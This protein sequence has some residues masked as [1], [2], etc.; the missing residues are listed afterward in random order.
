MFLLDTELYV[1]DHVPRLPEKLARHE[2]KSHHSRADTKGAAKQTLIAG[3]D[4]YDDDYAVGNSI[5]INVHW[6]GKDLATHQQDHDQRPCQTRSFDDVV[7]GNVLIMPRRRRMLVGLEQEDFFAKT[8]GFLGWAFFLLMRVLSISVFAN[9]HW[10][11]AVYLCLG[12]YLVVLACLLYEVKLQAKM[13]RLLF[14]FF[15]GYVYVF[16][17]MEF[18]IKFIH[19]RMWYGLY[20]GLVLTQNFLLSVWWYV[21]VMDLELWW[22]DYLFR[23][24]LGSGVLSLCC[25][26]V[27][28]LRLKPKD[29]VLFE[30]MEE[31]DQD[32]G[33]E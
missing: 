3:L 13:Q 33:N 25:L 7:D 29:K 23:T 30:L 20:V 6:T 9:L 32:Q 27:Y 28:Y 10:R 16:V 11:V 31:T 1:K 8:V 19:L 15:L 24:I 2:F 12:H 4:D 17:I 21:A 14:Y 18:K 26:V 5:A 22:F